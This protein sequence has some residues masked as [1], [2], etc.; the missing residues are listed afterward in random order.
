MEE[1]MGQL[2]RWYDIEVVYPNGIPQV[3]FGGKM[4]RNVPLADVLRAL[5]GFGIHYR[6]E[7]NRKLVVTP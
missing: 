3:T 6:M 2:T 4:S 7:A 5:K 1:V